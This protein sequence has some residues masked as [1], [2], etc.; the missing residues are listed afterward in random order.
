MGIGQNYQAT[1]TD[2][3]A[4]SNQQET[5]AWSMKAHNWSHNN[6]CCQQKSSPLRVDFSSRSPP[7]SPQRR[8]ILFGDEHF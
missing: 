7:L 1:H 4:M 2:S 5:P 6:M 8:Q 3:L